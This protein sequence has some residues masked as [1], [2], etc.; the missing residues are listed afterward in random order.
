MSITYQC[1][2]CG[3]WYTV[4][5]GKVGTLARCKDCDFEM[6]VP[7]TADLFDDQVDGPSGGAFTPRRGSTVSAAPLPPRQPLPSASNGESQGK[8]WSRTLGILGLSS[9]WL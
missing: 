9:L 6:V 1:E 2:R 5:E 3:K 7:N 8:F 4:R